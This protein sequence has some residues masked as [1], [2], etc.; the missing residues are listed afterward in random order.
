MAAAEFYTGTFSPPPQQQNYTPPQ[1]VYP[2]QQ[3]G[4]PP[5]YQ[6]YNSSPQKPQVHFAPTPGP[7]G[8][9]RPGSSGGQP[10]N[11]Q[12]TPAYAQ[13]PQYQQPG[14]YASPQPQQYAHN[15]SQPNYPNSGQLQP[16]APQRHHSYDSAIASGYSSDPERHH[17]RHHKKHDSR[18]R[19]RSRSRDTNRPRRT[20]ETSRSTNADGFIGAAGGG[21]IGDL[22]FPGLGTVGG[23]LAGW[24]GGKKY[25]KERKGREDRRDKTQYDWEDRFNKPH[26]RDL[27]VPYGDEKPTVD[28]GRRRSYDD[29][30]RDRRREK[31]YYT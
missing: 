20:S 7:H 31:K 14:P 30:D 1:N 5:P 24:L 21:L 6:T 4:A 15:Y 16:Y 25:G 28:Y 2:P 3:S 22:I 26:R 12:Y 10:P 8:H 29:R 11:P 9:N 27:D 23:A 18:S 13:Q 19:S 17:R